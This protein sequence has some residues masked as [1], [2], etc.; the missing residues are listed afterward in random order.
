MRGIK[1]L[2]SHLMYTFRNMS[3]TSNCD[4]HFEFQISAAQYSP[5]LS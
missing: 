1:F 3:Y 2:Y 5:Y 4:I